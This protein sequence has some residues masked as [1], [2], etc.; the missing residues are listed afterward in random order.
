MEGRYEYRDYKPEAARFTTED[1]VRDEVNRVDL[2]GLGAS[3]K[4]EFE[5]FMQFTH[6][7]GVERTNYYDSFIHEKIADNWDQLS[8]SVRNYEP[9]LWGGVVDDLGN[10]DVNQRLPDG[11]HLTVDANYP[12]VYVHYDVINP[13]RS[14]S[15][16]ALHGFLEARF[17]PDLPNNR[18]D[19][20][21]DWP[22]K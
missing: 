12:G 8:L 5:D 6:N 7:Q 9:I 13:L 11:Y 17:A 14:P 18:R 19:L 2:W 21:P 15:D 3:D 20:Y 4:E 10:H 1:P 16:T 22:A